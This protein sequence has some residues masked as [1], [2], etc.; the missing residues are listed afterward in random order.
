VKD[1]VLWFYYRENLEALERAGAQLVRLSLLDGDAWP[2]L[3]GCYLGGGFPEDAA[4]QLSASRKLPTLARMVEDG[5]P[6]FAECGGFMLLC[7]GIVQD[8]RLHP[9]A[10][11]FPMTVEQRPK[12]QGLGYVSGTVVGENP[13]LE[14]GTVLRG[15]E[16]H[17]SRCVEG[18]Q[19]VPHALQMSRGSGLG[20]SH[21]KAVDWIVR[22]RTVAGYTHIFAPA[23]PTWAPNFVRAASDYATERNRASIGA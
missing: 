7:R 14:C 20:T 21:G 1:N 2:E 22:K 19:D 18:V 17:Y 15:H 3:D 6:V 4:P 16:F 12:P 23:L 8:G 10:G 9:M 11:V 5:M 13:F